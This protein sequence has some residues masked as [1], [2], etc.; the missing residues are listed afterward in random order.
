M[1]ACFSTTP[2]KRVTSPAFPTPRRPPAVD[3]PLPEPDAEETVKEVLSE[4]PRPRPTS[5]RARAGLVADPKVVEPVDKPLPLPTFFPLPVDGSSGCDARSEATSEA[6]SVSAKSEALSISATPAE[7]RRG[8][9][10]AE[11]GRRTPRE[12]RSPAK[13][14]R[15][16]S[17]SG[18]LAC[19]RDRSVAVGCVSGRSSPSPAAKRTDHAAFGRTSSVREAARSRAAGPAGAKRDPGERSGRRSVSP[20][21]KRLAE[22]RQS[23]GQ[24]CRVLPPPAASKVNAPRTQIP[25]EEGE[26]MLC[27]ESD[28]RAAVAGAAGSEGEAKESLENPLVS[29]ECF[30]F[31]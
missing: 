5:A 3:P 24:Q 26:K 22:L 1:G 4:T 16:R 30:I 15:K 17:V 2:K 11:T 9:A 25:T 7:K 28:A 6:C 12:E 23:G 31:L 10:G 19:R 14:Q 18:E 27:T 21:A 20:A 8:A 29:L 13:Y